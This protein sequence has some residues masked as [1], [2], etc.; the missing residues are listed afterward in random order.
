[1]FG[2]TWIMKSTP[3]WFAV[4]ADFV[5]LNQVPNNDDAKQRQPKIAR[6]SDP[7]NGKFGIPNFGKNF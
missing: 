1:M 2:M 5:E 6:S 4:N 3:F 7:K